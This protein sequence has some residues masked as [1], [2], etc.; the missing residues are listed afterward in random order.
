MYSKRSDANHAVF[1]VQFFRMFID[2]E[3]LFL[4]NIILLI[5][6]KWFFGVSFSRKNAIHI[7]EEKR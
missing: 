3:H 7:F 5:S 2:N 4:L 6:A 1:F